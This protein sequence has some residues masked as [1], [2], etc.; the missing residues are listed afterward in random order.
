MT[1][2]NRSMVLDLDAQESTSVTAIPPTSTVLPRQCGPIAARRGAH[3]AAYIPD[4]LTPTGQ[5]LTPGLQYHEASPLAL[6]PPGLGGVGRGMAFGLGV[7]RGVG[8]TVGRGAGLG[9]TATGLHDGS[10]ASLARDVASGTPT[11]RHGP[12]N[13][14]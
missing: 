5:T 1:D 13:G 14:V 10:G 7:G 12:L 6:E 2:Q 3:A 4:G 8:L 9:T 11:G